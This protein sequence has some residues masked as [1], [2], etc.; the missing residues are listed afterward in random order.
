MPI[1]SSIKDSQTLDAVT[2]EVADIKAKTDNLPSDPADESNIQSKLGTPVGASVSADIASVKSETA[3][4]KAKTDNLPADPADESNIQGKLGTP[5]G[6]SVSAD[7]ASVK[8]DVFTLPT[9]CSS[10][11]TA[12]NFTYT[13]AGGEQTIFEFTPPS[14]PRRRTVQGVWLD[15]VNMTQNGIIKLYYKVDGTNYRQFHSLAFVVATDPDGIFL[16]FT[17]G[18][19]SSIKATYTE[20]VDETADRII[21]FEAIVDQREV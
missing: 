10:T 12:G 13:D 19:R 6:A 2:P 20:T 17:M 16:N 14:P 3:A 5:A 9:V 8:G 1:T 15:L 21:P 11:H 18:I 4:I 7:I